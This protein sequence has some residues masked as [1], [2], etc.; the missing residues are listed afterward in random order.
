MGDPRI[1]APA[2]R[3]FLGT[4]ALVAALSALLS[5]EL[6]EEVT[7]FLEAVPASDRGWSVIGWFFGGPPL[8]LAALAWNDRRRLGPGERLARATRYAAWFGLGGFVV[9]ALADN[10]VEL[11]G[12]G[13]GIGNPL[14][15]GWSCGAVG[16]L[17]ALGFAV[18][19]HRISRQADDRGRQLA[20]RFVE[21]GWVL[22]TI[23]SMLFAAY[24]RELGFVY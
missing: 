3:R 1:Q 24:G 21:W 18:A 20:L 13:V 4:L 12:E 19:I 23:G 10:S 8:V 2:T 6:G 9:P 15:F 14:A 17:A 22:L 11:F 16:N 7:T 5:R